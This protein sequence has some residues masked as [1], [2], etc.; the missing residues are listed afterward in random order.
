MNVWNLLF[1]VAKRSRYKVLELKDDYRY[2]HF[3]F[4]GFRFE[5]YQDKEDTIYCICKTGSAHKSNNY[6]TY[7]NQIIYIKDSKNE[8]IYNIECFE[9][10]KNILKRYYKGNKYSLLSHLQWQE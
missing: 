5:G 2:F 10:F 1:L 4:Q 8:V 6:H 3:V 9:N 7:N